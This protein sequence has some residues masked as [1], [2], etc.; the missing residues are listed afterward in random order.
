MSVEIIEN[1]VSKPLLTLKQNKAAETEVISKKS[2]ENKE[3]QNQD[4]A[5]VA[6]VEVQAL[7]FNAIYSELHAK[8]PEIINLDKPVLLAVGI[9]KEMS[10]ETGVS[11][12]V[13][14]RW[15]AWYCRKSKYYK[16]HDQGA[17]RYNLKGE[18]A[19]IVTEKHCEKMA[20]HLE[21]MK[22]PRTKPKDDDAEK[23]LTGDI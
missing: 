5:S 11:S 16:L 21:K 23:L 10:Q 6:Q 2:L 17:I 22:K 9:R 15:I 20:K 19:G 14:K 4:T 13:L 7:D 12:M 3:H 8:F 1:K 18:E